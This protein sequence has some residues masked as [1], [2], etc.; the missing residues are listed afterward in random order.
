MILVFI[1]F[2]EFRYQIGAFQWIIKW[3]WPNVKMSITTGVYLTRGPSGPNPRPSGPRGRP[4]SPTPWLASQG[5]SRLDLRLGWHVSTSVHNEGSEAWRRWRP[6]G[7]ADQPHGWSVG[8][9]FALNQPCQ[10]G[11][12]SPLPLYNPPTAEDSTTHSTCSSPL[13]KVSI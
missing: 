8:H 1:W 12:D 6:R 4:A 2:Q 10:V 11:G 7:V 13:V 3:R 9:P 5:L